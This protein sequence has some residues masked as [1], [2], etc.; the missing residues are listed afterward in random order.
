MDQVIEKKDVLKVLFDFKERVD[1]LESR[2]FFRGMIEA[3]GELEGIE[4]LNEW[5]SLVDEDCTD[6]EERKKRILEYLIFTFE[7]SKVLS[8]IEKIADLRDILRGSRE[9]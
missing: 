6:C 5:F 4:G 1:Y 3:Y 8:V 2:S 7:E 9:E